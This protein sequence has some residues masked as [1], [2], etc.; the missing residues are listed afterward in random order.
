MR[1]LYEKVGRCEDLIGHLHEDWKGNDEDGGKPLKILVERDERYVGAIR[2]RWMRH[3]DTEWSVRE[4]YHI[5]EEWGEAGGRR[6]HKETSGL[7]SPSEIEADLSCL[8]P[9]MAAEKRGPARGSSTHR[10]LRDY[11]QAEGWNVLALS[12]GRW[13]LPDD[14]FGTFLE[15]YVSDLPRYKLGLVVKKSEYFPYMM[16]V[17]KSATKGPSVGSPME[18]FQVVVRALKLVIG[19]TRMLFEH[20][21]SKNF[22]VLC[23]DIVVASRMAVRIREKQLV[24]LTSEHPERHRGREDADLKR[25]APAGISEVQRDIRAEGQDKEVQGGRGRCCRRLLR[26]VP[27]RF[28]M[29]LCA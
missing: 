7:V 17:D 9:A 24:I 6:W 14:R 22:H 8:S 1:Q 27:V 25:P 21:N 26:A 3:I 13:K 16:D 19:E 11:K 12:N 2:R 18:V 5:T 4:G 29:C 28:Q 23:P 10:L 20:R 15:H